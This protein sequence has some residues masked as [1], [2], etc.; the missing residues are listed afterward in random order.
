MGLRL[1]GFWIVEDAHVYVDLALQ[2]SVLVRDRRTTLRTKGPD[3]IGRGSVGLGRSLMH[4]DLPGPVSGKERDGGPARPPAIHAVAVDHG[5]WPAISPQPDG[6]TKAPAL[7]RTPDPA[8]A[9]AH[10][11]AF[12]SLLITPR[13]PLRENPA[14]FGPALQA[15]D[16]RLK[17]RTIR[18]PTH[19]LH[20]RGSAQR[21]DEPRADGVAFATSPLR[22]IPA[23]QPSA[24][25][26]D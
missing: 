15:R 18:V 26:E 14:C 23:L 9:L 8:A 12:P 6:S 16:R 4:F 2:P 17:G 21:P 24:K 13:S 11:P 5:R 10:P 22:K 1:E 20:C 3:D 19:I 7:R 25:N